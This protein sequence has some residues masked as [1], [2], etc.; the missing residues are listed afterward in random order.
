MLRLLLATPLVMDEIGVELR[1]TDDL[2]S[3]LLESAVKH[4]GV[5]GRQ[6]MERAFRFGG[7]PKP[8]RG[9]HRG[10]IA[11]DVAVDR[12]HAKVRRHQ[13]E[14]GVQRERIPAAGSALRG[15]QSADRIGR[16]SR[17][18]GAHTDRQ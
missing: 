10:G 7:G 13:R 17:F 5:V 3:A 15:S 16:G 14:A 8:E 18:D 4:A 9:N 12:R 11:L 6:E 1:E 2:E